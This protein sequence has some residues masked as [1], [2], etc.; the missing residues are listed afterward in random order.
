MIATLTNF[1]AGE[2]IPKDPV[3]LSQCVLGSGGNFIADNLQCGIFYYY[4]LLAI[5]L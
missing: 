5:R 3:G 4:Y 1:Y 2:E